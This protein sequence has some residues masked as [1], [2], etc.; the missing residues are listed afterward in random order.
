MNRYSCQNLKKVEALHSESGCG[1]ATRAGDKASIQ[2]V[3]TDFQSARLRNR[4]DLELESCCRIRQ[5]QDHRL[6]STV[7]QLEGYGVKFNHQ[8]RAADLSRS[9]PLLEAAEESEGSKLQAQTHPSD[10]KGHVHSK[11]KTSHMGVIWGV[12][13]ENRPPLAC[14]KCREKVE[15]RLR[16]MT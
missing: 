14:G 6:W 5:I 9:K 8:W 10:L 7:N 16:K 11:M 12:D 15:N 1:P 4:A 3:R 2:A 13:H